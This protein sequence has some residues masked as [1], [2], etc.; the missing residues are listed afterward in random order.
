MRFDEVPMPP[1]VGE[2]P[3]DARGYPVPA[4]TPWENGE[5]RFAL[6]DYGRA[7][8]C[9]LERLCSVCGRT[10]PRGPVWR[11]VGQDE[12]D[13]VLAAKESGLEYRNLE[14]TLEGPGHRACMLYA[15]MVCPFLAR[16][17]ARRGSSAADPQEELTAHV[18]RGVQR[19]GSG[20]VAGFADYEYAVTPDRV[21]FRFLD[22]VEFLP[23][24]LG[25]EHLAALLAELG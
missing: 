8:E 5:P 21:L 11:V 23:Y 25:Q 24:G 16:P 6:N 14:P 19:G 3:R 12:A 7:R 9:A 22:L 10:M 18:Q 2:R 4:I 17:N 15:A 13:A 1:A 20:A